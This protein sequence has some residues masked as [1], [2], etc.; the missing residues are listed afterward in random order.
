MDNEKIKYV[1]LKNNKYDFDTMAFKEDSPKE[2]MEFSIE[3]IDYDRIYKSVLD[4]KIDT[5]YT[6]LGWKK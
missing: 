5:F 1:F 4:K 3:N 2:I 6:A